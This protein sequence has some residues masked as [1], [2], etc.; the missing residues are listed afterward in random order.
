MLQLEE[1]LGRQ[2]SEGLSNRPP[3][4]IEVRRDVSF[5]EPLARHVAT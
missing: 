3:A 5:D 2:S 4:D 1:P